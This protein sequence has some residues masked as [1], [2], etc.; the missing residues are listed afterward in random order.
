MNGKE[1]FSYHYLDVLTT[2]NFHIQ[3]IDQFTNL[4]RS[5]LGID[6]T[7]TMTSSIL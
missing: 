2:N 7:S 3:N 1:P 6:K 4:P 5:P